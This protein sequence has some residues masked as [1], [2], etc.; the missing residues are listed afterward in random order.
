MNATENGCRWFDLG[1]NAQE[2]RLI[3]RSY[4]TLRRTEEL[5]FADKDQHR[6]WREEFI[7]SILSPTGRKIQSMVSCSHGTV[8]SMMCHS[9]DAAMPKSKSR[10]Q[11]V[12][13]F[14]SSSTLERRR[15][16]VEHP[17]LTYGQPND[18]DE[19]CAAERIEI[20]EWYSITV[21]PWFDFVAL[22]V[23]LD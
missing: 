9:T 16:L 18:I 21:K 3:N 4:S 22:R 10:R 14:D 11:H 1:R 17:C 2:S 19:K 7:F 5:R 23:S 6:P 15:F 13:R 8:K 20:R 12:L